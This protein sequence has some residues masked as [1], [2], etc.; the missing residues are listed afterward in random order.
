MTNTRRTMKRLERLATGPATIPPSMEEAFEVV[1]NLESCHPS[2]RGS[3]HSGIRTAETRGGR[4]RSNLTRSE[5][6]A[7][8]A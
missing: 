1:A 3:S 2:S 8:D 7:I 4:T 6:S 5:A